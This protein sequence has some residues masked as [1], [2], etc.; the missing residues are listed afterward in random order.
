MSKNIKINLAQRDETDKEYDIRNKE[1]GEK[2]CL[3]NYDG[4]DNLR[5]QYCRYCGCLH[6]NLSINKNYDIYYDPYL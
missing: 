5:Q 4:Q 6:Y 3:H 2:R 1:E